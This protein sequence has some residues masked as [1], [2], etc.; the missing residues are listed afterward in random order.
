MLYKTGDVAKII[1]TSKQAIRYFE[2]IKCVGKPQCTDAGYRTYDP[3]QLSVLRWFRLYRAYGLSMQDAAAAVDCKDNE[4]RLKLLEDGLRQ[5]KKS[6]EWVD[7]CIEDLQQFIED[8]RRYL[9]GNNDIRI[10]MCPPMYRL[11]YEYDEKLFLAG[12]RG[13]IIEDWVDHMPVVKYT[14]FF[15]DR[16][17]QEASSD[18]YV[19]MD[20][21]VGFFQKDVGSWVP[22]IPD[23]AEYYPARLCLTRM[24]S[25]PITSGSF[26]EFY[27]YMEEN[28]F[29]KI[30][31]IFSRPAEFHFQTGSDYPF[32]TCKFYVPIRQKTLD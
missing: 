16:D 15:H 6:R 13:K 19:P 18:A 8:A 2:K 5:L 31:E 3:W 28:D 24:I 17:I 11:K 7:Y 29:V 12:E 10:E 32:I 22:E 4:D 20:Y 26:S 25:T 9:R 1:G 14:V 21:G 23:Y 27:R 30:G